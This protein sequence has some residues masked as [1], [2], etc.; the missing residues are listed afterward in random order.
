MLLAAHAEVIVVGEA[1]D[2]EAAAGVCGRVAPDLVF[3]DVQLR[4]GTGFDLL[5]RLGGAPAVVFVSAYGEYAVRASEVQ[6]LTFLL[7][8]VHPQQLATTIARAALTRR[9]ASEGA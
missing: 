2:V 8:P 9:P 5:P 1:A 7:K 6:A 3:L 4:T